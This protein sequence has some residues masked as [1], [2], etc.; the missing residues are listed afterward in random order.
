MT[1]LRIVNNTWFRVPIRSYATKKDVLQELR[2]RGLISQVTEPANIL[3][4]LFAAGTRLKLYCGVDPTA[5]SIHLGNLVPM[6]VLLNCLIRG[7]DIVTLVG[8]AT[9]AIGDPSGRSDERQIMRDETRLNNVSQIEKQLKRFFE[10]G[11]KYYE[12]VRER[13]SLDKVSAGKHY[14]VDN[15]TWWKSINMLDFLAQYG[16][17]IKVQSMLS[18]ESVSARLETNNSLGFNE[19]TYQILQAYDFYHLY[20][21]K[22]TRIQVGGNDQWGNITAGIDLITRISPNAKKEPPFGITVPLLTTSSG[23]K[24]GKSA[25]NAIFIDPTINRPYEIYQFF[26]NT[27]D[28]DL[29]N[30]LRIFTLLPSSK[31]DFIIQEHSRTPAKH[32]GQKWLAREVT[33]LIHGKKS[34]EEAEVVSNILFGSENSFSIEAYSSEKLMTIFENAGILQKKLKSQD[35]THL[36]VS[37]TNCS[38]NEARRKINDGSIYLGPNRTKVNENVQN[39]KPH[40]INDELLLLRVGKQKCFVINMS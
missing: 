39:W 16:R 13:E 6:M 34:S 26:Y 28:A 37:L 36:L 38:N 25:G 32:I 23:Q 18:R 40:L 2:N 8:G 22:N 15:L 30:F 21:E 10:N 4:G 24:F 20:S 1:V 29:G 14:T 12:S 31:I 5:K 11:V 27:V 3:G 17:H 19:F 35:L 33:H 7:H 9:G